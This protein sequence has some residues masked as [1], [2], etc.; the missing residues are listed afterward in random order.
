MNIVMT[1][2]VKNEGDILGQNIEFHRRQGVSH[3]LITDHRSSDESLAIARHYEAL[4]LAD[5]FTE[6]SDQFRQGEWVT[7]MARLAST[8]HKA[9]WVINSDADEFWLPA[10][11]D[12][13]MALA[14]IDPQVTALTLPRFNVVYCHAY[15]DI[16]LEGK[17]RY[18][19]AL[20]ELPKTCHRGDP[21]ILISEGNHLAVSERGQVQRHG[22][23]SILHYPV[24]SYEQ[25]KRKVVEGAANLERT[26]D[27]DPMVG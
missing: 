20:A 15:S 21:S 12:L 3:F 10:R 1:L 19:S 27:L 2:M 8:K 26:T 17:F 23:I 25:F 11:G 6:T 7:R 9:D 4:G 18:R 16:I 24:R 14:A 5:V 13:Q 22:A